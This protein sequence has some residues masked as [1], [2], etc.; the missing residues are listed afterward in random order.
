MARYLY[1]IVVVFIVISE[2]ARAGD[3]R[4]SLPPAV[5]YDQLYKSSPKLPAYEPNQ[6]YHAPTFDPGNAKRE[7]DKFT[8][9]VLDKHNEPAQRKFLDDMKRYETTS[10]QPDYSYSEPDPEPAETKK[11]T[12]QHSQPVRSDWRVEKNRAGKPCIALS[13]PQ[14]ALTSE[15][16]ANSGPRMNFG[17][18]SLSMSPTD[19]SRNSVKLDL[20]YTHNPDHQPVATI[21]SQTFQFVAK[22][23]RAF[24][25]DSDTESRLLKAMK[26][27]DA[28]IVRGVSSEGMPREDHYSLIGFTSAYQ[29]LALMCR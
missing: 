17:A 29:T 7:M 15:V 20:A 24:P 13:Y 22:K 8:K 3:N 12:L 19:L 16:V 27:G 11:A 25:R 9:D 28:M 1:A 23:D 5:N 26:T 10:P 4:Y 2:A 14:I 18:V 6:K 21:Q